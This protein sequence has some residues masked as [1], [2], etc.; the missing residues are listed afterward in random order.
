MMLPDFFVGHDKPAK[1][2]DVAGLNAPQIVE[3]V[4]A[5]LGR[6]NEAIEPARA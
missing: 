3:T 2:Y 5:A 6:G 1:M 4:L